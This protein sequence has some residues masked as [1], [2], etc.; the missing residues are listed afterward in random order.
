MARKTQFLI[1][2][3]KVDVA[4]REVWGKLAS[5]FKD[6]DGERFHYESSKP[7]IQAWSNDFQEMTDGLSKGNLRGMHGTVAAGKFIEL[8]CND[9]T[10]SVDVGAKVIDDNEWEKVLEKVYN[11]FS[12]G[13]SAKRW[14]DSDGKKWYT[15]FPVEGSQIG[16]AHV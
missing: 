9:E 15:A 3:T 14:K 8:N 1:P 13:G 4:K 6:S 7:H 11:S 5:Q 16:R 12:I 10:E 2:I